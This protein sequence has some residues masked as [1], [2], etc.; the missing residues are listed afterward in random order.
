MEQRRRDGLPTT[1]ESAPGGGK[2]MRA[3][4]G[5]HLL[6]KVIMPLRGRQTTTLATANIS[7]AVLPS[8][9]ERVRESSS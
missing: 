5:N 9:Q 6:Q 1:P 3:F 8:A 4:C 7:A 2:S